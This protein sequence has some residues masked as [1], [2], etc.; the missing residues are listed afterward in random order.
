MENPKTN[1]AETQQGVSEWSRWF[2]AINLSAATR[3]IIDF[4]VN[5]EDASKPHLK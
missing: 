4:K 5:P 2:V 1:N 3:C